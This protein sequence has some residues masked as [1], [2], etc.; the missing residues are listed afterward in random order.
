MR[1]GVLRARGRVILFADA[2]GATRFSEIR[3]LEQ[4]LADAVTGKHVLESRP[5]A[6]DYSFP[7][8]AIGSRY[9]C[10]FL[11]TVRP[12]S[13]SPYKNC[14]SNPASICVRRFVFIHCS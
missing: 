6:F 12:V 9:A 14:A 3:K 13:T 2:D 10:S 1:N 11:I 7:A 5:D 4:E 8:V